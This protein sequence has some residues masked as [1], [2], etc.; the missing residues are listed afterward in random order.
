MEALAYGS[1]YITT[2]KFRFKGRVQYLFHGT[3][4]HW[5]A[6]IWFVCLVLR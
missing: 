1:M 5:M 3:S 2:S 4:F 6:M